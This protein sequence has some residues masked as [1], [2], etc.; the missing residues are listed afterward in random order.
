MPYKN[1]E[2]RKQYKKQWC[3]NNPEYHKQWCLDHKK[4]KKEYDKQR[5]IE[6]PDYHKEHN[7]Q[8]QLDHPEYAK[9]YNKQWNLD[10]KE[11]IAEYDKQ[12]YINN[13]EYFK[14]RQKQY[15]QTPQGKLTKR[16]HVSKRRNLGFFPLNEPFVDCEAHH[17]SQNFVIFIP[18]EIHQ[19]LYHN[20]WTWKNMDKINRLA[21]NLI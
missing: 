15:S 6:H 18:K 7:K 19:S 14:Q 12:R 1:K 20:I 3:L 17:I 16:R 4:D 9:Q 2:D 5:H 21:I 10:H 13:P 11:E 8:W